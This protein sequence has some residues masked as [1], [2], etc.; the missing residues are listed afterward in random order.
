M[1]ESYAPRQTVADCKSDRDWCFVSLGSD[2]RQ[3]EVLHS[4]VGLNEAGFVVFAPGEALLH[5]EFK[6]LVSAGAADRPDVDLFYGDDVALNSKG[7]DLRLKPD[8]DPIMHRSGD[9]IGAPL[10]VRA[11]ALKELGGLELAMGTAAL[12]DLILRADQQ[13]YGVAAIRSVLLASV[14][15]VPRARE[16]ERRGALLARLASDPQ[17]LKISPGL[18]PTSTCM[19]R[20]FGEHPDITLVVPTKQARRRDGRT[21]IAVMLQSLMKC[22]WPADRLHVL[23]GD[24]T[25][26]GAD[27]GGPFP[28]T[29]RR[30]A[31]PRGSD[32][33]FNYAAKMNELWRLA[34]SEYLVLMN[35]DIE[36][37]SPDWLETLMTFA[38]IKDV[39]GVG[40]RLLYPGGALQHAGMLGGPFGTFVH[41]WI[42]QPSGAATY[43]DWALLQ[44][45]YSAVTG[46][47]F[48][49]TKTAL[50]VVNGFDERFAV[51]YNDVDLCLRLRIA[52]Y[53]IVQAAD[54]V[55]TH[56]EKS[57]RG[58]PQPQGSQTAR[59]LQ[60]WGGLISDDPAFHPML[61]RDTVVVQPAPQF[62]V[63]Y[64]QPRI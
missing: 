50:S 1:T 48:A 36:V 9:Y 55:L 47:V 49:T 43:G 56:H 42:G 45:Q 52:G 15:P 14:G 4:T 40:A 57:S 63:W 33:E 8:F 30:V 51:E 53:R 38:M 59:F 28:F 6:A 3:A 37:V 60:R 22:S 23:V 19:K 12:Y 20:S 61:R 27:L 17:D 21:H 2:L 7:P 46:A 62:G 11:V 39:G 44:R 64:E 35:D 26:D 54:A 29:I 25:T 10:I 32:E 31:T 24:D 5:P 18:T 41:P 13:G 58:Q 34:S 16:D